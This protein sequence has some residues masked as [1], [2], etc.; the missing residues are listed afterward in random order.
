MMT[1]Q[2]KRIYLSPPH[3]GD[4]EMQYVREAFQNNWI[5]PVG[6]HITSF[7]QELADYTGAKGAVA[8]S[9]GTAGIHLA[10]RALGVQAGDSVFCSSFTFVASAN[11]ILYQG[12]TPIFIDSDP[13][14]WN[15]SPNALERAL[16]QAEK[17]N[18]LPKAVIV[19]HLYG[20]NADMDRIGRLCSHY[21][22]PII[23]DA[24]ES[25]GTTYKGHSSGTHGQFGIYSFN[26]N[27]II[28]TSNGGMIVSDDLESLEKIRK[29]STQSKDKAKHYQHSEIGYN[30]RMSNILAGI[31]RGQLKV[32]DERVSA[33]RKIFE[34][35]QKELSHLGAI[36]FMPVAAYGESTHWL[37]C[38]TIDA[39]HTQATP[40][41]LIDE[42]EKHNIESR[43][44]WKPMHLQPL[45]QKCTYY[46]H[47]EDRSVSD[48]LFKQGICL[49]S[50]SNLSTEDQQNIISKVNQFFSI[51]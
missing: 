13:A 21:N 46:S 18:Q 9:S 31:G 23:E 43:R 15:M 2:T 12:A 7:E 5:A 33:R 50:G 30:Y 10:L 29:W 38:F 16:I 32:L 8:L 1:H 26:G 17:E 44:L 45:Y 4:L 41:Q 36:S 3:I 47:T 22:V 34:T 20:Q 28:T 40:D 51:H 25:L 6:P 24:A 48:E 27:K 11:P 39:N 42:L 49:P 19:V 35:Y 14:T 37:T